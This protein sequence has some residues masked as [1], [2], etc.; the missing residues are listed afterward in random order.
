MYKIKNYKE[1]IKIEPK[2]AEAH[3]N[4]GVSLSKVGEHKETLKELKIALKLFKVQGNVQLVNM[5]KNYL[6]NS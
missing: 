1:V 3:N 6:K 2:R 4:L 5:L